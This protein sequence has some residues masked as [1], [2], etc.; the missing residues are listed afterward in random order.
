MVDCFAHARKGV[1]GKRRIEN[2]FRSLLLLMF[3]VLL[4]A[5]QGPYFKVPK[6][7]YR[8][9]VKTLGILPLMVDDR[10][11]IEHPEAAEIVALLRKHNVGRHPYLAELLLAKKSYFDV[12]AVT[13]DPLQL[14]SRLIRSRS[15]RKT[16]EGPQ[17]NYLVDPQTANELCRENAVDGLL[18]VVL[19]G[20]TR[21]QKRWDRT[22]I[23]YLEALFNDI[24][25]SAT[26]VLPSG[27]IVWEYHGPA[28]QPFLALQYPD[29]DEAHHNNTDQV[30]VHFTGM[31]GLKRAMTKP[32]I[33][34]FQETKL[35]VPYQE[36][37]QE[38]AKYLTPGMLNP[39]AA[40]GAGE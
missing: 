16:P 26:V 19:N 31:V 21:V 9:Q 17:Y 25:A 34:W 28:G 5:C 37:F 3:L 13:G 18:V 6:D 35:S 8:E 12:R 10:S 33:N 14:Y 24:L 11:A 30:P 40:K 4:T 38:L 20:T 27:E 22:H 15:V 32:G 7:Q 39:F 23:N 2:M 1:T 29:F 36:L